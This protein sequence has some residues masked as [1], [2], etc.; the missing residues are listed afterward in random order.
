MHAATLDVTTARVIPQV[1]PRTAVTSDLT[2]PPRPTDWIT[3]LRSLLHLRFISD[4]ERFQ[5]SARNERV[6]VQKEY[7]K[8]EE[9]QRKR[10]RKEAVKEGKVKLEKMRLRAS[11][12]TN[13]ESVRSSV[14]QVD[15]R[16]NSVKLLSPYREVFPLIALA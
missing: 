10:K 14:T 4:A 9:I 3:K 8:N 16:K 2:T 12:T 15:D 7:V 1:E 11:Q 6:R 13:G 5:T